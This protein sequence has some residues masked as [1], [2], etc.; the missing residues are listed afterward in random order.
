V[1]AIEIT[2]PSPG[3]SVEFYGASGAEPVSIIDPGWQHLANRRGIKAHT[4]VSLRS[5]G[6]A[7]D[8]LLVWITHAPSNVTTGTVG[9][10]ELSVLR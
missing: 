9:V 8:F 3:M 10:S 4:T 5:Q 6:K 7:F 2:T 1:K